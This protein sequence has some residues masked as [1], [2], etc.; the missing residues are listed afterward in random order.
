MG[1][2]T[3]K[4]NVGRLLEV[5]ADAGYGT[6]RDVDAIFEAITAEVR[7]AGIPK[8]VAVVDWRKCSFMAPAAAVR[9]TERMTTANTHTERSAALALP[10]S[11]LV[12]LQFLR[13]IREAGMPD[14]KLF[15]APAPLVQWLDE[16]LTAEESLRLRAFIGV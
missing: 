3:A 9:L 12:V 10:D 15:F 14:R 1:S 2:N 13:V 5:R 16:V 11:P 7:R 6:V 8:T 4:I